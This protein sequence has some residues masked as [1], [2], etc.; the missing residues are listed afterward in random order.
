MESLS[1]RQLLKRVA[2]STVGGMAAPY[3]I[4]AG[5][6]AADDTPGANDR[7]A[8]GVIGMGYRAGLLLDQLPK[9]AQIVAV[10]DCNL[11]VAKAYKAKKNAPWPIFQDHH[12]LLE[13]KDV[14][15]VIVATVEF[16]RVLPC[17]DACQAGKD[18]YA[19]KPLT[20]HIHEGRVLVDAVRKY[21]RVLQV[22]T[23]QR[24]MAMNQIASEFVLSGGLGKVQEVLT[25]NYPGLEPVPLDAYP[26]QALPT[27][28]N[29]NVWLNQAAWRPFNQRWM[30]WL[31][32]PDFGGGEM[33][34]WG[35]HGVDQI[36]WVLGMDDTG[37]VEVWPVTPGT[38]GQVDMRYANGVVV[39]FS[40]ELG[41]GPHAGAIFVCEKG[42]LE[43]NRNKFT[44]NPK[45]IASELLK[46][47]DEVEEEKKWSDK[48]SLYQAKGHIQNW[49]DC[50]RTRQ[51]PLA[52]VEIGHRSI[53]ACHLANI[54]RRLGRRLKWDPV[55]EQFDGDDEANALVD[56]PRRKGFELP[57]SV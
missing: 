23:Q 27:G 29:W 2:L 43:I 17:I 8:I 5:V 28:L 25:I 39:H 44:S 3:L 55:K 30:K 13:R 38:N 34:L 36:Q 20:L 57:E 11:P 18:I 37:P 32:C 7:I 54:A 31:R 12:K 51:K 46:K 41:K 6:L 45:E 50:I 16:Q 19:E 33:T 47:V 15:A 26:K 14:D 52:D 53:T 21:N 42:K 24:S 9:E 35:A 49:L 40:I 4:P 10:S 56:P 1:R 22:G 48:T